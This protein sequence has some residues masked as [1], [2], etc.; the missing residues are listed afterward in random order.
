MKHLQIGFRYAQLTSWKGVFFAVKTSGEMMTRMSGVPQN[1]GSTTQDAKIMLAKKIEIKSKPSPVAVNKQTIERVI[2]T[3]PAPSGGNVGISRSL[4][5]I[6]KVNDEVL[7]KAD[8]IRDDPVGAIKQD[9][10]PPNL[11]QKVTTTHSLK[12]DLQVD[13]AEAA[14]HNEVVRNRDDIVPNDTPLTGTVGDSSNR[15]TW[16]QKFSTAPTEREIRAATV[17]RRA[18]RRKISN[19]QE[20]SEISQLYDK[21]R[22]EARN[23]QSSRYRK[24]FLGPLLHLHLCLDEISK[25]ALS[26]KTRVKR[27]MGAQGQELEE[28]GKRQTELV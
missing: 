17:L 2:R 11:A 13:L 23:I 12:V 15:L 7:A 8:D 3:H 26:A 28:L 6:P 9:A 1:S 21:Y 27:R 4:N 10:E 20:R 18:F 25:Y 22:S 16:A 19:R 14:D 24:V 5:P